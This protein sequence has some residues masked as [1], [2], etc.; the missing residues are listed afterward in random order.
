MPDLDAF[1]QYGAVGMFLAF[2]V[3]LGLIAKLVTPII[4]KSMELASNH[5][6]DLTTTID[7]RLGKLTE[8][9]DKLQSTIDRWQDQEHPTA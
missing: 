8:S 9:I 1:V 3:F 6:T 5:L 7:T 2:L 4:Q